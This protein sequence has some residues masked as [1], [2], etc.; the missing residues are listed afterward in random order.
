M[1]IDQTAVVDP[2]LNLAWA[3]AVTRRIKLGSAVVLATL[4]HPLLLAKTTAG[5]HYISE[6][7][8]T[9]G[10]SLGGCP[11]EVQTLGVPVPQRPRRL[12]ETIE[13]LR[14]LWS[15][16]NVTF[17]G[18]HFTLEGVTITSHLPEGAR[19][20]ILLGGAAESA[21][22]RAAAL[23]DGWVGGAGGTVEQ[24]QER[25]DSFWRLAT[26]VGRDPGGLETAKILWT[27]IDDS[28]GRAR[29]RLAPDINAHYGPSFDLDHFAAFGSPGTCAAVAQRYLDTGVK[30]LI[31]GLPWPDVGELERLH[32]EVVPLLM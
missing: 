13:I 29:E 6:G 17:Q 24:V 12:E 20:P 7:R 31:M 22:K 10:L 2:F 16:P 18:R 4:R 14:L 28:Q 23:A 8:L 32:Q 3:A 25:L 19:I 11:L 30:T 15:Q 5:L 26:E 1:V 9:L 27:A 21:I